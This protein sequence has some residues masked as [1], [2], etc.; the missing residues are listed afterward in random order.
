M[1]PNISKWH[2]AG[3]SV[4]TSLISVAYLSLIDDDV[5]TNL[6]YHYLVYSKKIQTR[7]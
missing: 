5:C 1:K 3:F 6:D 4:L 2:L 7:M